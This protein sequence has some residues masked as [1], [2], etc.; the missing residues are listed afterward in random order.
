MSSNGEAALVERLRADLYELVAVD[1]VALPDA[2]LRSELVKLLAAANQLNAAIAAR[3]AS[4]DTRG[5]ADDDAC[6]STSVWLRCYGRYSDGA[7]SRMVKQARLLRDL[8]AVAEAAGRGD[9]TAEHVDRIAGLVKKV[10]VAAVRPADQILADAA[11]KVTVAELGGLCHRIRDYVDPDGPEPMELFDQR[12][13]TLSQRDGM[14]AIRGQLDPEGGAAVLEALD[15][16]MRPPGPDDQR[17]PGQRRADAL[18][19]LARGALAQGNLPTVGGMRPQVGILINA[20]TLLYGQAGNDPRTRAQTRFGETEPPNIR[21]HFT[22]DSDTDADR[23]TDADRDPEPSKGT[24]PATAD[25]ADT[26]EADTDE[27]DTDE[28]EADEAEADEAEADEAEADEGS[29]PA[30]PAANARGD[31][32]A[33]LGIPPPVEPAWLNWYGSITPE[34]AQRLVCDSTIWRIILDPTTGQPLNVGRAYRLV[35][36]WIRRALYARD[37]GCRWP[38]CTTPAP[39]TDAHHLH[40]WHD[41]GITRVE[42]ML[43]LCRYHHVLLHEGGWHIHLDPTTGHVTVTRPDGTPHDLAS[44]KPWTTPTTQNDT[45]AD[46]S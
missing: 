8:P 26:D 41:G 21:H 31:P 15:A 28:A 32:L 30:P 9:V 24:D 44:S 11:S 7:S 23:A 2:T 29:G 34:T 33:P 4:F 38:G 17:T 1:V 35:P 3:L 10:G 27:A 25:Q 13:F 37:R 5:L 6:K 36:Y 45:P 40:E 20:E 12:E 18:V 19:E 46:S 42:D 14:V 39:W 43:L 22:N 16:L